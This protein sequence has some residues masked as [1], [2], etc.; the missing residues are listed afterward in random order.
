[1]VFQLECLAD[2]LAQIEADLATVRRQEDP[3]FVL[4]DPPF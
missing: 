2:Q 4:S 1:M 3:D